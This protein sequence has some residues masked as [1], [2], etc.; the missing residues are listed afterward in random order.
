M[1]WANEKI[2]D[3]A[4][5]IIGPS[6]AELSELFG[7]ASPHQPPNQSHQHSLF[8]I[9]YR[10][11]TSRQEIDPLI[12]FSSPSSSRKDPNDHPHGRRDNIFIGRLTP[13]KS[14]RRPRI[15][16]WSH[17]RTRASPMAS[18]RSPCSHGLDDFMCCCP[19]FP[20]GCQ[21]A[22]ILSHF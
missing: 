3:D 20:Q 16:R 17:P 12:H 2:E 19:S 15:P 7:C 21:A 18:R 14:C 22:R 4:G 1:M 11:A 8:R 9:S 6:Q 10:P 13:R 5:E